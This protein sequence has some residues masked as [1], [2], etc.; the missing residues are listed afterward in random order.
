MCGRKGARE[1]AKS[2][3]HK[4]W[5]G[6]FFVEWVLLLIVVLVTQ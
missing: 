1:Y 4:P 2:V 3:L 6:Y 5:F